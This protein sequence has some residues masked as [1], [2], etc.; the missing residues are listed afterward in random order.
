M[1]SRFIFPSV[2]QDDSSA[3]FISLCDTTGFA[4]ES[5]NPNIPA[6]T[7][8]TTLVVADDETIF[9]VKTMKDGKVVYTSYT[10]ISN[11]PTMKVIK[12]AVAVVE[13][14]ER[15]ASFIYVDATNAVFTGSKTI[16]FVSALGA[17]YEEKDV[18]YTYDYVY[19]N[20]VKTSIDVLKTVTGDAK[21]LF[22][23]QGLYE[24]NYDA[25]GK[26]C[27]VKK[28]TAPADRIATGK[29]VDVNGNFIK[30]E[31]GANLNV[32]AAKIYFVLND[33]AGNYTN[34]VEKTAEDLD[35]GMEFTYTYT[36]DGQHMV[37]SL[38]VISQP[39]D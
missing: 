20:G 18:V 13:A 25:D 34:V 35:E 6:E 5:K 8:K 11:V 16:A 17:N 19:I 12:D 23:E 24:L 10:G 29:V 39:Q 36:A 31:T 22:A 30:V 7:A 4:I 21:A 38:Y 26:V 1:H 9:L 3:S 27:A 28:L 15:F 32:S 14:G 37:D 33:G 2:M